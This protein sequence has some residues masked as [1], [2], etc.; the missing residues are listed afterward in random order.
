MTRSIIRGR[1]MYLKKEK[2]IDR[3]SKETN[4]HLKKFYLGTHDFL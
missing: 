1:N 2:N 3:A 4:E